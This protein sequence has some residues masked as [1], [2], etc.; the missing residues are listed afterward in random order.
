MQIDP[1]RLRAQRLRAFMT[2][3]DLAQE[4]GLAKSTISLLERGQQRARIS[5]VRRLA[6]AFHVDPSELLVETPLKESR[7]PRSSTE[8]D[9]QTTTVRGGEE[10]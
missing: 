8:R 10:T 5:T 6:E 4:T 1:S 7:Y 2:Q 9:E 3:Q